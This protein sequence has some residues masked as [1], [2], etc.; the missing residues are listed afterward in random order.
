MMSSAPY[1]FSRDPLVSSL[2][3]LVFLVFLLLRGLRWHPLYRGNA[4]AA[5]KECKRLDVLQ[6]A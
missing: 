1:F 6:C 4:G 2:V 5:T 3:F